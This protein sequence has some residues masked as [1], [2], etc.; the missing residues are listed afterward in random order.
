MFGMQYVFCEFV[1][2]DLDCYSSQYNYFGC[3]DRNYY[4]NCIFCFYSDFL[5]LK[6]YYIYYYIININ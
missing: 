2:D 6:V 5:N 4:W 1:L 3:G